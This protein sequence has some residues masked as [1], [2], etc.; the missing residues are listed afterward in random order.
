MMFMLRATEEVLRTY[1]TR[2]T[3][4]PAQ[5]KNWGS[6]LDVLRIPVLR[7]S[8]DLIRALEELQRKRNAAMH[9]GERRPDEWDMST[10]KTILDRC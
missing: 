6:L 7:C 9:P 2:V 4:Q 8:D 1:Y 3:C 5:R 10:A